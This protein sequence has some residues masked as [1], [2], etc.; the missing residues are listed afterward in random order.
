MWR[1]DGESRRK[2]VGK[3]GRG[4]SKMRS[5]GRWIEILWKRRKMDIRKK[6]MRKK[7]NEREK[8]RGKKGEG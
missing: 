6:G 1:E 5:L 7:K 8:K 3:S 4:G 2:K